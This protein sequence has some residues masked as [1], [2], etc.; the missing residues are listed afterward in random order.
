MP[1]GYERLPQINEDAVDEELGQREQCQEDNAGIFSKMLFAWVTPMVHTGYKRPLNVEDLLV[2]RQQDLADR[3]SDDW[4]KQW[5]TEMAEA[6]TWNVHLGKRVE[7]DDGNPGT[8]KWIGRLQYSSNPQSLYAGVSWDKP[9]RKVLKKGVTIG[10][11]G[12]FYGEKVFDCPEGHGSFIKPHLLQ[13]KDAPGVKPP[14]TPW[15]MRCVWH[16]FGWELISAGLF[17]LGNDLSQF[18][19]PIALQLIVKFLSKSDPTWGEGLSIVAVLF[20]LQVVQSL[21]ANQYF[22]MVIR[23]GMR[24]RQTLCCAVF[25]KA[26]DLNER[27]RANPDLNVGRIVN[28]MSTDAQRGQDVVQN[29]HQCWSAPTQILICCVLLYRL[30]GVAL[31]AGLGVMVITSPLQ[32]KL[33]RKMTGMREQMVKSTD[34]RVKAVTEA[35]GGIRIVKFM[36]WTE[37]FLAQINDIRHEEIAKLARQQNYRVVMFVI[38]YLN[39]LLL[40][41]TTF[42][43][44]SAMGGKIDADTVFPSIAL[45]SIVRFP[46]T[47]LPLQFNTMVNAKISFDRLSIYFESAPQKEAGTVVHPL[48][49]APTRDDKFDTAFSIKGTFTAWE[50]QVVPDLPVSKQQ[51]ADPFMPVAGNVQELADGAPEG[52]T[53]SKA[54]KPKGKAARRPA[55]HKVVP[56]AVLRD[57]DVQIRRKKLTMIIGLTGSGKTCLLEALLGSIDGEPG[58][59]VRRSGMTVDGKFCPE[60]VAYAPQQAWI[61][62]ATLKEN[63]TFFT[64]EDDEKYDRIIS[65]CQLV[66]DIEQLQDGDQTEIGEKGINLSGGQKQRT[67]I[68][69]AVYSERDM[70]MLDDP[71]SAVD[72]F[73]AKELMRQV[74]GSTPLTKPADW[75]RAELDGCTRVLVTHQLQYVKHADDV[76]FMKDGRVAAFFRGTDEAKV[77]DQ[78]LAYT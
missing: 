48:A 13:I 47:V 59:E 36:A 7:D 5:Q 22:F 51:L 39:P 74:I 2:P 24:I 38:I 71:L 43:V 52:K 40:T 67:S 12:Y 56:K 35:L 27:T 32:T 6:K 46:F 54:K 58:S 73:V 3:L 37:R 1:S 72:S 11:D 65:S 23:S 70:I 26:L 19:G 75:G 45:F 21:C 29:L 10:G 62:N 30:V 31:F 68:A 55:K 14:V 17:K 63:V 49:T 44:Y 60:D 4:E 41:A 77:V 20:V 69:R 66:K 9:R 61:M 64:P 34:D 53:S 25:E 16:V 8:L 18:A 15:T 57:L 33:V 28:L 76:I 42:I 78:V 50:P